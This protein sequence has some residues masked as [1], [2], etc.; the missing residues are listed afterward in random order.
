MFW[1]TMP[2]SGTSFTSFNIALI[3]HSN[4]LQ[5]GT[6]DNFSFHMIGMLISRE[7]THGLEEEFIANATVNVKTVST[8]YGKSSY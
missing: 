5:F 2:T 8:L 1:W 6:L 4:T 3:C 7:M